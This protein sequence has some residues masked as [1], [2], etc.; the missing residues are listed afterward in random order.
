MSLP[1][2]RFAVKSKSYFRRHSPTV[3]AVPHLAPSAAPPLGQNTET[4]VSLASQLTAPSA[5]TAR[6][7]AAASLFSLFSPGRALRTLWSLRPL[8]ALRSRDALNT[9]RSLRS[10]RPLRAGITLWTGIAAACGQRK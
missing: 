6:R 9:L 8:R 4:S 3:G 7:L 5:C 1:S 10:S 2:L